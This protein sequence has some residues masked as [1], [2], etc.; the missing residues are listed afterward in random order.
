[1]LS[2]FGKNFEFRYRKISWRNIYEALLND[3]AVGD[4][5]ATCIV[6][7]NFIMNQQLYPLAGAVFTTTYICDDFYILMLYRYNSLCNDNVQITKDDTLFIY[8]HNIQNY[9]ID[10]DI[11]VKHGDGVGIFE[12]YRDIILKAIQNYEIRESYYSMK[13][14]TMSRRR[15]FVK[16]PETDYHYDPVNMYVFS[17]KTR[18]GEIIG[19][20][21]DGKIKKFEGIELPLIKLL[22][23]LSDLY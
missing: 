4:K 15:K 13:A 14:E 1:M 11:D 9:W 5:L 17:L 3:L 6:D 7:D 21:N 22:G 18:G 19:K 12:L 2:R 8:E 10:R 23:Y 20:F 16:V